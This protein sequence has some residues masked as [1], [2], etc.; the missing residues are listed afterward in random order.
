[1]DDT[2]NKLGELWEVIQHNK[3]VG[4]YEE[5]E[6]RVSEAIKL[7]L[8]HG[9]TN[10]RY[11]FMVTLSHAHIAM[12]KPNLALPILLEVKASGCDTLIQLNA[13]RALLILTRYRIYQADP[14]DLA[15]RCVE[16]SRDLPDKSQLVSSLT[17]LGRWLIQM[18]QVSLGATYLKEALEVEPDDP[19]ALFHISTIHAHLGHHE[20]ALKIVEEVASKDPLNKLPHRYWV[21]LTTGWIYA[22][23][24]MHEAALGIYESIEREVPASELVSFSIYRAVSLMEANQLQ[25][26]KAIL[27][28]FTSEAYQDDYEFLRARVHLAACERRLGMLEEAS[29]HIRD[30]E[31]RVHEMRPIALEEYLSERVL[32]LESVADYKAAFECQ[33]Q[34]LDRRNRQRREKLDE[35]LQI[36]QTILERERRKNAE[37]ARETELALLKTRLSS[38]MRE[39]VKGSEEVNVILTEIG[40]QLLESGLPR[41][42]LAQLKQKLKSLPKRFTPERFLEEF[43]SVHPEFRLN[44]KQAFPKITRMQMLCAC[45]MRMDLS[46]ADSGRLLSVSDRNIENHRYRL[47]KLFGLKTEEKLSDFLHKF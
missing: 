19:L 3:G 42:A 1:M 32:I 23:S 37:V 44:V 45:T 6:K 2:E 17:D 26:A 38:S 21:S 41:P 16:L 10:D 30:V 5:V 7:C 24:G 28:E 15:L 8:E 20:L 27:G 34:L 14:I 35:T 31:R 47:R 40:H 39:L 22:E 36:V 4:N 33:K 13:L 46:A 18:D 9:K 11:K 12:G 29:N 43:D 25:N